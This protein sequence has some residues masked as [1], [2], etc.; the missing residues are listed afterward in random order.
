MFSI[1]LWAAVQQ[2]LQQQASVYKGQKISREKNLLKGLLFDAEGIPYTPGYTAKGK[3]QYRYYISQNLIQMRDHPDGLLRRLPAHE[4]ENAVEGAI[5]MHLSGREKI[6]S[7]LGINQHE[8]IELIQKIVD[9]QNTIS[10]DEFVRSCIEQVIV[11]ADRLEIKIR[12]DAL[13]ALLAGVA[14]MKI[15][16]ADGKSTASLLV[17]Y[18]IRRAKKGALV[19]APEK[20]KSDIFDLPSHE[21]KKLVQGFIWRDEHFAGMAIKDIAVRENCSQS[22][23]GTAIFDSFKNLQIA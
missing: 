10:M 19:I 22:Y 16:S 13:S 17:T 1:N 11:Q 20:S 18:T 8:E 9:V 3:K 7:L 15:D 6:A 2:K 23:V 12:V 14:K 21:L 5:R 4:I